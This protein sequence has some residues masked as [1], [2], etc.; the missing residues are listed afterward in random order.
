MT[1]IPKTSPL[2]LEGNPKCASPGL[3]PK[4]LSPSPGAKALSQHP[5]ARPIRVY[6]IKS[7]TK[8]LPQRRCTQTFKF[9]LPFARS[10]MALSQ[11]PCTVKL[12]ETCVWFSSTSHVPWF[13]RF[14]WFDR[15]ERTVKVPSQRPCAGT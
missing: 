12:T 6:G 9:S 8:V 11:Y 14:P 2:C 3:G 5:C 7:G 1:W 10:T 4:E 15:L 13:P